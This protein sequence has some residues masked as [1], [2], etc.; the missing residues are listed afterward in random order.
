M[1]GGDVKS[2]KAQV[3]WRRPVFGNQNFRIEIGRTDWSYESNNNDR[4]LKTI[5]SSG[6]TRAYEYTTTPE[7]LI[8]Q[9]VESVSVGPPPWPVQTWDYFPDDADRLLNANSSVGTPFGYA[10]DVADNITSQ[11][12]KTATYNALNQIKTFDGQAFVYDANG[13]LTDDGTRKY[14]WDAENR[15][16]SITTKT[17]KPLPPTITWFRYDGFGRRIAIITRQNEKRYLWCGEAL[18]HARDAND[19]VSRRYYPEGE[20]IPASGSL[21]YY[22]KD[23]LGSVRDVLDVR[24]GN[25]LA[26]Y[27]FDPY[28]TPTQS[29]GSLTTDFRYAGMFYH[30][31][32][33]L[34]LT[35][36]RAYDARLGR[37]LSRDPIGEIGGS[38][39]YADVANSPIQ[40]TDQTGLFVGVDDLA[41]G[42]IAV[43]I[44]EALVATGVIAAGVY[45]IGTH[46]LGN[47]D[48]LLGRR[49][50]EAAPIQLTPELYEKHKELDYGK[51][52][53]RCDQQPPPGLDPCENAKWRAARARDCALMRSEWDRKYAPGEHTGEILAQFRAEANAIRDVARHCPPVS[54]RKN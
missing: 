26:S 39:P 23:H 25:S 2:V 49:R 22:A 29:A 6:A 8:S 1:P 40:R 51:Y 16:V 44:G 52:H 31:D 10:Y 18:C 30:Q 46:C 32:S 11:Q 17:A 36:Y 21:L 42:V 14:G 47:L 4:R 5:K 9:I 50:D 33:G 54:G 43:A 3:I 13:N 53:N 28:G 12:G 24:N 27:D 35:Q 45:C 7:N 19:I 34:Y 48:D 38:N 37:W 20:V 41:A 15:L